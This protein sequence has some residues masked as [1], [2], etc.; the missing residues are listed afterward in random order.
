MRNK[1]GTRKRK[2]S[3]DVHREEVVHAETKWLVLVANGGEN[4]TLGLGSGLS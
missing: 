2:K 1:W 3:V 4:L